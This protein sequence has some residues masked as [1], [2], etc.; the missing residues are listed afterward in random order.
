MSKSSV[1]TADALMLKLFW[2]GTPIR[3]GMP[4][5]LLHHAWTRS[6]HPYSASQLFGARSNPAPIDMG[7]E[8][9]LSIEYGYLSGYQFSWGSVTEQAFGGEL[10]DLFPPT[11]VFSIFPEK[12]LQRFPYP[13]LIHI[14]FATLYRQHKYYFHIY[15]LEPGRTWDAATFTAARDDRQALRAY[16]HGAFLI[17]ILPDLLAACERV[18]IAFEEHGIEG[19]RKVLNSY[20]I[21][22]GRWAADGYLTEATTSRFISKHESFVEG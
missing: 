1:L 8:P 4:G 11:L 20:R 3:L 19:A 22:L 10:S 18:A 9:P 21:D 14:I 7:S 6:D 2:A 12:L 16:V 17:R 15:E 13:D 5:W